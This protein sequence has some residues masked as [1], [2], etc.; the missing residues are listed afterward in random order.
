MKSGLAK[1]RRNVARDGQSDFD[2]V[3]FRPGLL[4]IQRSEI[5]AISLFDANGDFAAKFFQTKPPHFFRFPEPTIQL[6]SFRG[7]KIF[8]GGLEFS[9]RAH[10]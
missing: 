7:G 5:A 4:R 8:R 3:E 9:N 1:H 6:S 2:A 10:G